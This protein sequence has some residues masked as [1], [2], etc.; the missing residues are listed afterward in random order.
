M[1]MISNFKYILFVLLFFGAG[2]VS[3]H[4]PNYIENQT[5]IK[6]IEPEI[7]K[8]YYGVL[9]GKEA[10]YVISTTTPFALYVGLLL[11]VLP[12]ANQNISATIVNQKGEV[13]ETLVGNKFPWK[14]WFE[15]FAGDD[16]WQGPEFK[17]EV[18]AGTYTIIV[19]SS[20]NNWDKYVLA[21]GEKESFSAS[22]YPEFIKQIYQIKTTFFA[23]SWW[24]IFEGKIGFYLLIFL[25]IISILIF[26]VS[27]LG[28]TK[29]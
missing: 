12:E 17:K 2:T 5:W 22:A 3:A 11:P 25:I 20:D 9:P 26:R 13:I 8:A 29:H 19:Y 23:K 10:R 27:A 6:V 1:K 4:Q 18:P 21:I 28:R 7:S 14:K 16:Y 24:A 15:P